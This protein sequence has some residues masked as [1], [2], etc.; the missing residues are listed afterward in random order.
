MF[1][2]LKRALLNNSFIQWLWSQVNA[3]VPSTFLCLFFHFQTIYMGPEDK[4]KKEIRNFPKNW[5]V[6]LVL[7]PVI[8]Q[9]NI[10]K[11]IDFIK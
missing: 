8:K 2:R 4:T 6:L 3:F 5:A 11:S 7:F 10:K 9:K 1:K